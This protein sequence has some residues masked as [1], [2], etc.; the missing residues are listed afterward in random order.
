MAALEKQGHAQHARLQCHFSAWKC[1]LSVT[2]QTSC[3]C[4]LKTKLNHSYQSAVMHMILHSGFVAA[5]LFGFNILS[6]IAESPLQYA[7]LYM[8]RIGQCI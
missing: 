1:Q 2:A 5:L 8:V 3:W 4:T 6:V 7:A